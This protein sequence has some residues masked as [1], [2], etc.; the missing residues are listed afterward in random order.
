MVSDEIPPHFSG[1]GLT[2]CILSGSSGSYFRFQSS[3]SSLV[4]LVRRFDSYCLVYIFSSDYADKDL[5]DRTFT[6]ISLQRK[7]LYFIV[8][9][10]LES[11]YWHCSPPFR[12][13]Q[14]PTLHVIQIWSLAPDLS[15]KLQNAFE[16][17]SNHLNQDTDINWRHSPPP[18][19]TLMHI[20]PHVTHTPNPTSTLNFS[21]SILQKSLQINLA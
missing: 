17:L 11:T 9:N 13:T 12:S 3:L 7:K 8:V 5:M 19:T 1:M 6:Q 16:I 15:H 20:L 18:P 21:H 2:F 10:P 14:P 4:N